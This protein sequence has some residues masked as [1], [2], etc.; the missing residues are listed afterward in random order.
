M[1]GILLFLKLSSQQSELT[2]D[3]SAVGEGSSEGGVS[4]GKT[5]VTMSVTIPVLVA[6]HLNDSPA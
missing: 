1:A 4:E 5:S 2:A 6:V 3:Y